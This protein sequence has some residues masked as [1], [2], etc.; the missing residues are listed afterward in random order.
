MVQRNLETLSLRRIEVL[1]LW[2]CRS[3]TMHY[4]RYKNETIWKKK[5]QFIIRTITIEIILRLEPDRVSL[6]V[7]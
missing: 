2:C 3:F 7:I 4:T 5:K 1:K 6:L